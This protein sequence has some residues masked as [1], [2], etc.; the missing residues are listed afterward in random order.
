[1]AIEFISQATGTNSATITGI[2]SGDIVL[3]F[4]YRDGNT[5]APTLPSSPTAWNDISSSGGNS[6]SSR[7]AWFRATGTSVDSGTFTNATS[8][9]LL[10]YR[11]CVASG[12]P[13]G[14]SAG[15][16]AQSTNVSYPALSLT[17]TDGSSWVV[18][19]AGH[20][21]TNTSLETP[22]STWQNRSSV[23]DATDEAA[24]HDSDGGLTSWSATTVSV[25]GTS[26]GWRSWTL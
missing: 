3:A 22:P 19:F 17:V 5:T 11:G 15:G 13:I 12:S 9:V 7:I 2:Q 8:V 14:V 24:G 21:S 16:G 10:A 1:M 26:S 18:G 20:R 23:V 4:A 6:N 25:G